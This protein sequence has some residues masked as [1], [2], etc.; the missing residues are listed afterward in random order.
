M[1]I[2]KKKYEELCGFAEERLVLLEE[3]QK[4]RDHLISIYQTFQGC[5][6]EPIAE[7]PVVKKYFV[8]F[9]LEGEAHNDNGFKYN[10][11]VYPSVHAPSEKEA[12]SVAMGY[13]MHALS[14]FD[15]DCIKS[16]EVKELE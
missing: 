16:I 8:K 2:S 15:G 11:I 9:V 1:F 6:A 7:E 3:N 13:A 4:L 5:V 12:V 10:A 14:W